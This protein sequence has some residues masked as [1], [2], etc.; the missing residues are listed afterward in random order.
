MSEAQT[1]LAV[2]PGI[3]VGRTVRLVTWGV[4]ALALRL[5]GGAG[6]GLRV[7]TSAWSKPTDHG[8]HDEGQRDR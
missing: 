5:L 1:L 4:A 7:Q 6:S 8:A 2:M 3:G